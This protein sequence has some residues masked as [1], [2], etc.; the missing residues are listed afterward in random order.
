MCDAAPR[1]CAGCPP[2]ASLP[3]NGAAPAI[4][5]QHSCGAGRGAGVCPWYTR[6]PGSLLTSVSRA[7]DTPA[8]RLGNP[9]E[10]RIGGA[11]GFVG[12]AAARS[13]RQPPRANS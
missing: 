5:S 8:Q 9:S 6:E 13:S 12:R 3:C 4:S 11:G 1:Q 2:V 10:A 7:P